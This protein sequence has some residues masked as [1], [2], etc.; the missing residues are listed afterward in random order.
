MGIAKKNE[1]ISIIPAANPLEAMII[2]LMPLPLIRKPTAMLVQFEKHLG[3]VQ[4]LISLIF[5]STATATSAEQR[6]IE[7]ESNF[8]FTSIPMI[9]N[10][11][12]T[13]NQK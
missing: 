4:I 10:K 2:S 11:I 3:C 5:A 6:R 8:T 13:K 9:A 7:V 12:E 1:V